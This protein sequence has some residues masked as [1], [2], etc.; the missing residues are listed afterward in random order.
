[1]F[2]LVQYFIPAYHW[3]IWMLVL[4]VLKLLPKPLMWRCDAYNRI[5]LW[6]DGLESIWVFRSLTNKHRWSV[7]NSTKSFIINRGRLV[8]RNTWQFFYLSVAVIIPIPRFRTY[9]FLSFSFLKYG[10]KFWE[11]RINV[12]MTLLSA[13]GNQNFALFVSLSR[14]PESNL[15]VI[16]LWAERMLSELE[17]L[18]LVKVDNWQLIYCS[19]NEIKSIS[20]NREYYMGF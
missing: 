13:D 4:L 3:S 2:L 14:T 16:I 19:W 11:N 1:M 8:L 7:I 10:D 9:N 15:V 20:W 12:I 18:L 17:S 6:T 5:S